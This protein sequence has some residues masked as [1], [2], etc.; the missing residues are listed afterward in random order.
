MISEPS[1]R[2]LIE[3]HPQLRDKCFT[4]FVDDH[5]SRNK[6]D[7]MDWIQDNCKGGAIYEGMSVLYTIKF[8]LDEDITLFTL[9]WL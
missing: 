2:Q 7:V 3:G 5:I 9:R 1:L 6:E 8:D 4:G